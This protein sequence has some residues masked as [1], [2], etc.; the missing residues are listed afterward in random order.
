MTTDIFH[1]FCGYPIVSSF[2]TYHRVSNKSKRATRRMPHVERKGLTPLPTEHL[3]SSPVFS[4]VRVAHLLFSVKY[5]WIS[6]SHL[7]F[8]F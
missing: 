4:V 1:K 6:V 2:M 7:S 3:S 5:L 8:F